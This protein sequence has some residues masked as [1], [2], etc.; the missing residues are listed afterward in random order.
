MADLNVH[1]FQIWGEFDTLLALTYDDVDVGW[2][3]FIICGISLSYW[4]SP[5]FLGI[6]FIRHS[7]SNESN[8]IRGLSEK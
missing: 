7:I 2:R 4:C 1:T 8:P 3:N 6:G 5:D